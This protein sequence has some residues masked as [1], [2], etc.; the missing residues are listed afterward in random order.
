MTEEAAKT[1]ESL[2]AHEELVEEQPA[3]EQAVVKP[4]AVEPAAASQTA[5]N[6]VKAPSPPPVA[7]VKPI[8][9]LPDRIQQTPPRDQE[10]LKQTNKTL[11]DLLK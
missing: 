9:V 4:P 1:E 5:A 3:V 10:V 8:R 7:A 2:K 6:A 11:D